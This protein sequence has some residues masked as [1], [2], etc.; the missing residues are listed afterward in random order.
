[1]SEQVEGQ[2]EGQDEGQDNGSLL[3]DLGEELAPN[4]TERP[5]GLNEKYWDDE[6]KSYKAQAI[7]DDLANQEKIAKDLRRKLGKGDHKAPEDINE[8]T[9]T[10][11]EGVEIPE[12]LIPADDPLMM[13][14]KERAKEIGMSK[15]QF[16]QFM[17]PLVAKIAESATQ[18]PMEPTEEEAKEARSEELNKLG[19]N[20]LQ[21]ARL[22]ATWINENV[23]KGIWTEQDAKI[24]HGSIKT[25]EQLQ[26]FNKLRM[27]I[28]GGKSLNI[29]DITGGGE[30][31][32][33]LES[34]LAKAYTSGDEALYNSV[35]AKLAKL[36]Q[37]KH[38]NTIIV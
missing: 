32:A 31:R 1:M 21:I 33:E 22:N 35:S 9:F 5:E 27:A 4:P 30:T 19:P 2:V 36:S 37:T 11:P 3:A 18:A 15:E 7:L 16:S 14:A 26:V 24:M 25:A 38:N 34:Q 29:N 17:G 10:A 12:G 6:N 13:L 8:Y 28:G 23:S 20:G